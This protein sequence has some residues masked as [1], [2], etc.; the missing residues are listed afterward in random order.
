[1]EQ[2]V[3]LKNV[4]G[5]AVGGKTE[6]GITKQTKDHLHSANLLSEESM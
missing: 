3:A 1:V 5:F 2:G 6:E 4:Y